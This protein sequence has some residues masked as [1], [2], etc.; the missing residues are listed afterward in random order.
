MNY[1]VGENET[2]D[3]IAKKF[4]INKTDIEGVN[5]FF[6]KNLIPGQV[7]KLPINNDEVFEEYIIRD[8][9]TLYDLANKNNIDINMLAEINGLNI[10]DYL[11]PNQKINIPK[12]NYKFYITKPLD[13]LENIVNKMNSNYEDIINLN[14]KIYLLP[15]QLIVSKK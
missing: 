13:T 7:I 11:Y 14:K 8:G 3:E 5:D 15:E 2:L 9:D 12:N 6:S 10:Y 4:D 1:T